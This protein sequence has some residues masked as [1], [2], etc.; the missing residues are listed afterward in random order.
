MATEAQ[1][2]ITLIQ[3]GRST[4]GLDDDTYRSMLA[5]LCGGKTSSKAL[6]G[7]ERQRVI[8]HMRASGF[9]IKPKT[10]ATAHEQTAWQREPQ[11]RK[12]RAMWYLLADAGQVER[13]G[14]TPACNAAIETWALRQ[15]SS[16]K[17]PLAALRFASG[18]QMTALVQALKRW[19]LRVGAKV[20]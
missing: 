8:K 4:L 1:R 10:G 20:V 17:P 5:G 2:E 9:V 11:L 18:A 7:P 13:P 3:I 14:D 15:L 12:L 6:T 16:H 19:C